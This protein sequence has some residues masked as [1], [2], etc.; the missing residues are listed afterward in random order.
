M[1]DKFIFFLYSRSKKKKNC[2]KKKLLR[3][4]KR[5][6]LT[7]AVCVISPHFFFFY[8]TENTEHRTWNFLIIRVSHIHIT[9]KFHSRGGSRTIRVFL[10]GNR[11]DII[12]NYESSL[13][14]LKKKKKLKIYK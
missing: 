3:S 9:Y 8:T 12:I 13:L 11:N 1:V 14:Q 4:R 6:D 10:F 2:F 7:V 5:N